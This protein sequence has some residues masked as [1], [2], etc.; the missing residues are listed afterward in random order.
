MHIKK[1]LIIAFLGLILVSFIMPNSAG[2]LFYDVELSTEVKELD[3]DRKN[4][5]IYQIT[6]WN[7]GEKADTYELRY[8]NTKS[9]TWVV[10]FTD[11]I[12]DTPDVYVGPS[13][14]V[15]VNLT[16]RPSCGCEEGNTL[17][18]DLT[19][20]SN[21]ETTTFDKIS[22]S[23]T[24]RRTSEPDPDDDPI[25]SDGDGWTDDEET[26][27]GTN[28]FDKNDYPNFDLDSDSDGLPDEAEEARGTNPFDP[29]TDNDGDDDQYEIQMGT[30][31]LDPKS[32]TK[33]VNT[34]D[35]T[36]D[37][38]ETDKN[39]F[40]MN[41]NDNFFMLVIL[42]LVV[43]ILAGIIILARA[44][45]KPEDEIDEEERVKDLYDADRTEIE[46]APS[47]PPRSVEVID[48][49][50]KKT[51]SGYECP[52]CGRDCKEKNLKKHLLRSH[53]KRHKRL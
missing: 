3:A 33:P 49:K 7:V 20:Y 10:S 9:D 28:P 38:E 22:V 47:A 50:L 46:K 15:V 6:I 14:N 51:T 29:D 12:T 37:S 5:A 27:N 52:E 31:P 8:T 16:V 41:I 17:D 2:L 40:G 34:N 32:F 45:K 39:I 19:A 13:Q 23:T 1:S 18:V 4:P 35:K 36:G 24:Y 43:V 48:V 42:I 21:S 11:Y 25:D 44:W 53:H 26:A 30:D